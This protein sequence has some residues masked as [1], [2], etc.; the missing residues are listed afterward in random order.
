MIISRCATRISLAGGSTDLQ[1]FIDENGYG[2]VISFPCNIYTYI[3]LFK[4]KYGYNKLNNYLLNYTQREEVTK[5]E[6]IHNDVAREVLNY[7]GCEPVTLNFHSDVFS[8]GSGLASS[9]SYLVNCIRA[10]SENLNIKLN[11]WEI[12]QLA[13]KLER[14]F[15]PLTGYQDSYGCAIDGFKQFIFKKDGGVS[16]IELKKSFL[17]NFKMYL[18]PTLIKRSSTE[19][20]KS[21]DIKKAADLLPFVTKM[22]EA[23]VAEKKEDFLSLIRDSWETKKKTSPFVLKNRK[24]VEMEDISLYSAI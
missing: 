13:L 14:N 16:S 11:I 8:S 5:I 3:T 19:V 23:I 20:L 10:V 12:C 18:R 6:D 21:I 15:N 24:L 7:F 2:S 22:K 1:S 17:N 4:D 9:S